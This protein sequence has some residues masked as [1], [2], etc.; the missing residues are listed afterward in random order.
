MIKR[1]EGGGVGLV[2]PMGWYQ[3]GGS[4]PTRK[5]SA[6]PPAQETGSVPLKDLAP[7][8]IHHETPRNVTGILDNR[9]PVSAPPVVL[10]GQYGGADAEIQEH[11]VEADQDSKSPAEH[12]SE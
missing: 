5:L 6:D 1:V 12:A 11:H 8:V 2:N 9:T 10:G 7:L 3:T 4:A